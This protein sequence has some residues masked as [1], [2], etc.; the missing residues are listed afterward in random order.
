M[1]Y[2]FFKLYKAPLLSGAL[3]G[4]GFIP[5]PFFSL[6]FA[7]VPLW[8]FIYRQ[9]HFKKMLIGCFLCQFT[10]TFIGFNWMIYTFHNFGGMNW[11]LSFCL[12]L[13]FCSVANMYISLSGVLWF[14]L[15]KK[16][17]FSVFAKLA[18][19]PL[20]FSL[21]HSLIP[22]LFPWNMGYPWL[23]GGLPGA[24]TAELWGFRFLNTLFYIFNLLFL[25]LYKH[26]KFQA[27]RSPFPYFLKKTA[28]LL[29]PSKASS[30]FEDS[31]LGKKTRSLKTLWQKFPFLSLSFKQKLNRPLKFVGKK[32]P[33]L[34]PFKYHLDPT[35]GKAL[36]GAVILFVGLNLLGLYLKGRLPPANQSL[37]VILVQ[38]NIGSTS[39][40]DSKYPKKQALYNLKTL[41]YR[42]LSKYAKSPK[43]KKEIDFILWPEGAYP[44]VIDKKSHREEQLSRMVKAIKIPLITGALSKKS[45]KYGNSLFVFNREGEILKPVYDKIKLLAFGEYFPGIE[46]FPFLRKLFPY[47]GS[48]LT[49]GENLETQELESV[50]FGWQICYEALFDQFNRRLAQKGAQVL[51]NITNDSWYGFWQEPYQHLAMSFARAIEVRR[52]L[53]RSTNTGYS[54]LIHPD[55]T[56]DQISPLNKQWFNLYQI[57]YYKNPPK[58]LFMGWGYYINEIFLSLLAVFVLIFSFLKRKLGLNFSLA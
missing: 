4:F 52:P 7:L 13:F 46:H 11:L 31:F 3:F 41:S 53:I 34:N 51:V 5:F 29:K 28:S 15:V 44:Y 19:F 24:Q 9:N 35:G 1:I 56:V 32:L 33:F 36:A 8:L 30:F 39:H 12:L 50:R 20:I 57:P 22:T 37:K 40:L 23:W 49:P 6:L 25:I 17:S 10:A 26:S 18:L 47:F 54:G 43:E 21:L 55:G 27:N 16:S 14:F 58:T 2:K 48:N 42:A 45:N 38:N